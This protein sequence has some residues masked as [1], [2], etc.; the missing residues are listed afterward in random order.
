MRGLIFISRAKVRLVL[1]TALSIDTSTTI[2]MEVHNIDLRR[3]DLMCMYY[4]YS[5]L[6]MGYFLLS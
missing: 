5:L 4:L 6:L 1:P 3:S 2:A